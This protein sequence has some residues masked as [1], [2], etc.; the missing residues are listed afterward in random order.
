MPSIQSLTGSNSYQAEGRVI[1]K[2]RWRQQTLEF[3]FT[4]SEFEVANL[5]DLKQVIQDQ[6]DI[7]A[8]RQ[9]FLNLRNTKG[10]LG[11]CDD[12]QLLRECCI[13]AISG[14]YLLLVG[15]PA[16]E[17]LPAEVQ[18]SRQLHEDDRIL[19]YDSVELQKAAYKLL[20]NE[21]NRQA[22][23]AISANTEIRMIRSPRQ[24]KKLL[25][26][27]L[28][29][30]I[31]DCKGASRGYTTEVL[32]RPYLA[33]FLDLIHPHFDLVIWSQTRWQWVEAKCTEL[34]LLTHPT[35]GPCFTL[36]RSSMITV[37]LPSDSSFS[38]IKKKEA[39]VKALQVIWSK[40]INNWCKENTL[41]VDDL[42]RNF[43]LNP[44]NGVAVRPYTRDLHSR[45]KEL[46]LLGHY[47]VQVAALEDVTS[48][49][50]SQWKT[51]LKQKLNIDEFNICR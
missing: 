22:L 12:S 49:I 18:E 16:V 32:K 39:E 26:L 50:H 40:N 28:D 34:G 6:L 17:Q 27:D 47:L 42:P 10:P 29:Y 24:G 38:H 7:P 13:N 14:G 4:Q 3:P 35:I 46:L 23:I 11:K 44:L 48:M 36:D 9:K 31:Y 41:I 15:T 43:I 19:I 2:C 30:T 5:R 21:K 20:Q 1:L 8:D 25:V 37:Q 45:D 33:Q 51:F